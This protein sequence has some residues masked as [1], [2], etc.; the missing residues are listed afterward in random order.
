VPE[1]PFG[2]LGGAGGWGRPDDQP[3]V[4]RVWGPGV[5]PAR[6]REL[7]P[8]VSDPTA[9]AQDARD[10][11]PRPES[12]IGAVRT[13][14]Q[15]AQPEP[16]S[17]SSPDR[18]QHL[19]RI[20]NML[21][22]SRSTVATSPSPSTSGSGPAGV[23]PTT[24]PTRRNW[25]RSPTPHRAAHLAVSSAAYLDI[26]HPSPILRLTP[27]TCPPG[28]G[29][30]RPASGHNWGAWNSQGTCSPPPQDPPDPCGR[31]GRGR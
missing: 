20:A 8:P 28:R 7:H 13:A 5:L 21:P 15:G 14:V 2:A 6:H 17:S 30:R 23:G 3:R 9:A 31:R 25:C 4:H 11:T 24:R 27:P 12:I 29:E 10:N 1:N 16:G 18:A 26:T 22:C 19:H